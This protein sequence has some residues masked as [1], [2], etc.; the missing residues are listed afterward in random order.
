MTTERTLHFVIPTYRL[1]DVGATVTAYDDVGHKT[2][3]SITVTAG[4][5]TA[6]SVPGDDPT[7]AHG[8]CTTT[9]TPPGGLAAAALGLAILLRRRRRS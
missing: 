8:G 7:K 6:V 2:S 9:G 1:R 5:A 4:T 3:T